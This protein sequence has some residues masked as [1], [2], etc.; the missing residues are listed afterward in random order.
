MN[1]ERDEST[2]QTKSP[3]YLVYVAV[4]VLFAALRGVDQLSQ[5]MEWPYLVYGSRT[6]WCILTCAAAVTSFA[7]AWYLRRFVARPIAWMLGTIVGGATTILTNSM[8][9]TVIGFAGAGLA[10]W[11]ASRRFVLRSGLRTWL[12]G[13]LVSLSTGAVA[14]LLYLYV[15]QGTPARISMALLGPLLVGFVL[16]CVLLWYVRHDRPWYSWLFAALLFLLVVPVGFVGGLI[17]ELFRIDQAVVNV[18]SESTGIEWLYNLGATPQSRRFGKEVHNLVGPYYR[19]HLDFLSDSTGEDL[20]RF[21]VWPLLESVHVAEGSL[22]T[23]ADFEQLNTRYLRSIQISGDTKLTDASIQKV[24]K[25]RLSYF[26]ITG[27]NFSDASLGRL[28]HVPQMFY[29]AVPNTRVTSAP[30]QGIDSR[31]RIYQIDV[32][33]TLVDD[34]LLV[35]LRPLKFLNSLLLRGTK[36]TGKSLDQLRGKMIHLNLDDTPFEERYLKL[37]LPPPGQSPTAANS[38]NVASLSLANVPLT[39]AAFADIGQ[40]TGV[41]TLSV[42]GNDLSPAAWQQIT[43]LPSLQSLGID[44][45]QVDAKLVRKLDSSMQLNLTYDAQQLEL[46]TI[47]D[48]VGEL[49]QARRSEGGELNVSILHVVL[50]DESVRLLLKVQPTLGHLSLVDAQL[51]SGQVRNFEHTVELMDF[52]PVVFRESRDLE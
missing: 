39:D 37:L 41:R 28:H 43:Q 9:G 27:S 36:V 25:S 50:T 13:L 14:A 18:E 48:R 7:S 11:D 15:G 52:F 32:S 1:A 49:I 46:S 40:L 21:R 16:T 4:V 26:W 29:L 30:F 3:P 33:N 24:D 12:P 17:S 31:A 10:S 47:L 20:G 2:E 19:T 45:D 8:V 51:P 6:W 44:G 5:H 38:V 23:D 35:Y 42:V 22:I 34:D